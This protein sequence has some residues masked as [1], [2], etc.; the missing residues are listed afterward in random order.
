MSS[1]AQGQV[2][3]LCGLARP[4]AHSG[5]MAATPLAMPTGNG[6]L[7]QPFKHAAVVH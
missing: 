6:R 7:H 4:K 1:M 2:L 3:S 5:P